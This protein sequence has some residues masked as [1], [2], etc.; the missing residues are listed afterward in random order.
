MGIIHDDSID[1]AFA[2]IKRFARKECRKRGLK[3]YQDIAQQAFEKAW[4]D[5]QAGRLDMFEEV[6]PRTAPIFARYV[7]EAANKEYVDYMYFRGAY[8]YNRPTVVHI[9]ENLAWGE[10]S[11]ISEAEAKVD[12]VR[13]YESLSENYRLV[14]YKKYALGITPKAGSAE[15]RAMSRAID[16]LTHGLNFAAEA[17]VKEADAHGVYRDEHGQPVQGYH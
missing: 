1:Q 15:Q 12:V 2:D 4:R 8:L 5:D 6:G 10:P 9:L 16:A 13:V 17:H 7:K 14:L 3:D 11:T